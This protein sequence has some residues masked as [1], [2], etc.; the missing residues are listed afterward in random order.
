MLSFEE[1]YIKNEEAL[2][3]SASESGADRELDFDSENYADN[4]YY[5]Y[6]DTFKSNWIID[7][8]K[9]HNLNS[10]NENIRNVVIKKFE[11]NFNI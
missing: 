6:L 8:C 1:W 11:E 4:E 5:K 9:A 3:I 2:I 10:S 7:Y